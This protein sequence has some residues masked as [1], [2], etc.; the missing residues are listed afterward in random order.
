MLVFELGASIDADEFRRAGLRVVD[1]SDG[2]LVVAFADDPELAAFRERLNA[3]AGGIP[4]GRQSEPYA[5][6]FDAIDHIRPLAPQD[7]VTSE[8]ASVIRE[9]S[10]DILRM[11]VECWHP[12]TSDRAHEWLSEVRDGIESAEG[13]VVDTLINDSAGLVLLRAYVQASRIM[14]VAELDAIA[15]MDVLPQPALPMPK[16]YSLSATELPE[17]QA[18]DPRSAIVGLVDSGVASGHPLIGAAVLA[19]DAI[20]TGIEE[21]QD[22]H[23]HGT[24]VASLLLHGNVERALAHGLPLRPICR[25]VSARVL[26]ASNEFPIDD[27]MG[28]RSQR[29]HQ[30]VRRPGCPHHQPVHR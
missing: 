16:L 9:S 21:D 3:F 17:V 13:R 10:S 23:G 27:L 5:Q 12:G 2:L 25:V 19:S 4:E 14:S 29:G 22:E 30:M 24:M 7:R 26:D 18:P 20:G 6:F 8:L 28:E 15:R 1:S 11:D